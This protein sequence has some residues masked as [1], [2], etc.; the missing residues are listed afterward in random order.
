MQRGWILLTN[1][2]RAVWNSYARTK[3]VFNKK[4]D[5]HPLSGHS[6]WLKYQFIYVLAGLP[7]LVD[8][9]NYPPFSI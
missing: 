2:E 1:S 5:K 3:P 4:G 6:L 8:P 7:F 9:A